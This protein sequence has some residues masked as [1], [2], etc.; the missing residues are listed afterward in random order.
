M[1]DC[2]PDGWIFYID[3]GLLENVQFQVVDWFSI[4]V[5]PFNRY[6]NL[7]CMI[8]TAEWFRHT[9]NIILYCALATLKMAS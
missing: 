9:A 5:L 4:T 8:L 1:L 2:E 7:N 6:L 3:S